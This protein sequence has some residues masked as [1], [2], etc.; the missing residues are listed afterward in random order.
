[1]SS[2]QQLTKQE[3]ELAF[4]QEQLEKLAENGPTPMNWLDFS[5]K[6][7]AMLRLRS[8]LTTERGQTMLE[9][10]CMDEAVLDGIGAAE[11]LQNIAGEPPAEWIKRLKQGP[12]RHLQQ[13]AF[14]YRQKF[15]AE[16]GAI[17]RLKELHIQA[18]AFLGTVFL[19]ALVGLANFA[20]RVVYGDVYGN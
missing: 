3:N 9:C 8:E 7:Q 6:F 4:L 5:D 18:V 13:H 17:R 16:L 1:M 10:I 11:Q 2:R 12:G 19:S 20:A 15:V 14:D